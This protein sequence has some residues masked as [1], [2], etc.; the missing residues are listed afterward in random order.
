[1]ITLSPMQMS[2][3]T[4]APVPISTLFPIRGRARMIDALQTHDDSVAYA[5]V[6]AEFRIT[7]DDNAAEVIDDEVASDLHFARQIDAVMICTNL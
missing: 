5:A 3:K 6:V 7:A 4:F 2:P 1:M